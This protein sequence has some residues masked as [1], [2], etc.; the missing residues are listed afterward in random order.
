MNTNYQKSILANQWLIRGMCLVIGITF[1][2]GIFIIHDIIS[3]FAWENEVSLI[4]FSKSV[5]FIFFSCF[6]LFLLVYLTRSKTLNSEEMTDTMTNIIGTL[7]ILN[8]ILA[9]IVV[10][11]VNAG[12]TEY[13]STPKGITT[14]SSMKA[15][16]LF[17]PVGGIILGVT[18]FITR[19]L[20]GRTVKYVGGK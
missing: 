1:V 7:C 4:Y 5:M 19:Y 15:S 3:M 11:A 20:L 6:I 13:Y 17:I 16:F 8:I 18:M 10:I 12:V 14:Y 2:I 9:I